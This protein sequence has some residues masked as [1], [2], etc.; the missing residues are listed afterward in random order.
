MVKDHIVPRHNLRQF[1]IH[2]AEEI[3]VSKVSPYG[4]LG[5][6]GIGWACQ[7]ADF[8]EGNETLNRLIWTSENDLAPVVVQVVQK[9]DF[10]EPEVMALCMLALRRFWRTRTV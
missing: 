7:Q 1:A 8:Y 2:G 5:K 4:H 9:E 6:K 10:T 3:M